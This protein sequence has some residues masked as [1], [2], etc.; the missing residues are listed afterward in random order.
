M[1]IISLLYSSIFIPEPVT[2]RPIG[3][4][5]KDD[6]HHILHHDVH[7]ILRT[8]LCSRDTRVDE[9]TPTTIKYYLC[10]LLKQHDVQGFIKYCVFS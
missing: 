5:T 7:L 9:N 2:K 8:N 6:V 1:F 4:S 3:D 10:N